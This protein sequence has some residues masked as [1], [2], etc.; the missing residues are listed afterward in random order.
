LY[1][2]LCAPLGSLAASPAVARSLAG[3]PSLNKNVAR[4]ADQALANRSGHCPN[5]A[6]W[7]SLPARPPP[8]RPCGGSPSSLKG[9]LRGS[10]YPPST[11]I[12]RGMAAGQTQTEYRL[13]TGTASG[14]T[15][16]YNLPSFQRC[17]MKSRPGP[18]TCSQRRPRQDQLKALGGLL[19]TA[20]AGGAAPPL[21]LRIYDGDTPQAQRPFNSQNARLIITNPDMLHTGILPHHTNW[22]DFFAGLRYVVIEMLHVPRDLRIARGER[23]RRLKRVAGFHGAQL[24]FILS[25]ATIGNPQELAERLIE[26]QVDLVDQD[27]SARGRANSCSTTRPWWIRL[28]ACVGARC[29]RVSVLPGTCTPPCAD[30]V[31]ARSRRSVELMLTHLQAAEATG[32][33]QASPDRLAARPPPRLAARRPPS[34]AIAPDIFLGRREIEQGLRDGTIRRSSPRTP[35]SSGIDIAAW[36]PLCWQGIQVHRQRL[37]AS[38]P[39]RPRRRSRGRR[40]CRLANPLDQFLAH[41]PDYFFGQSLNR[42]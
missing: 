2:P 30:V 20:E 13:A 22:G 23:H 26:S 24:Q 19:Q 14:K 8:Q 21:K 27:G 36:V 4:I 5:F 42:P 35:S 18:C 38:G 12:K 10:A 15:L 39:G 34:G 6:V 11:A 3:C 25:S 31:F 41:H 40:A 28:W 37:S 9:A 33:G 32:P 17:L 29:W 16:A 1:H 7:Q